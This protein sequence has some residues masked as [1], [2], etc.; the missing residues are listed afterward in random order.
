MSAN[1]VVRGVVCVALTIPVVAVAGT[2]RSE[3]GGN[4][5]RWIYQSGEVGCFTS[6]T[7][8]DQ[9]GGGGWLEGGD[10]TGGPGSVPGGDQWSYGGISLVPGA[11]YVSHGTWQADVNGGWNLY[12]QIG[13]QVDS[14]NCAQGAFDLQYTYDGGASHG[15]LAVFL[16][17]AGTGIPDYTAVPYALP[18][19]TLPLAAGVGFDFTPGSQSNETFN[20]AMGV[21]LPASFQSTP[22][23]FYAYGRFD[24]LPNF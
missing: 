14:A 13:V 15:D 2:S 3:G 10:Q 16:S 19:Q 1:G 7:L 6:I 11:E 21:H 8:Q 22:S 18:G 5:S 9:W 23:G 12:F 4:I 17:S 20:Y 24:L